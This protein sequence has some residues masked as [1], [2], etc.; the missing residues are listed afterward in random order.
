MKLVHHKNLT[1]ERWK[2]L[3]FAEQMANVGSEV[4]RTL[5]WRS[6]KREYSETAFERALELL[7]LIIEAASGRGPRL[8]E[9]ARVREALVDYFVYDNSYGSTDDLWRKYFDAFHRAAKIQVAH[10]T[11][12]A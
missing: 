9:L 1:L 8:R 3:S 2:A 11:N 5:N 6:K 4:Y 12:H 10:R 7:D